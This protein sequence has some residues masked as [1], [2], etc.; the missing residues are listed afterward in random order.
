MTMKQCQPRI[1]RHKIYFHFLISSNYNDI[2][3][4]S[5]RH[6]PRKFR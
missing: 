4:H 6:L 5:G 2:L 3:Y 1:V